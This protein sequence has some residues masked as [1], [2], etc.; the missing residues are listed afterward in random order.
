MAYP[1]CIIKN[2]I[3]VDQTA[4]GYFPLREGLK[5]IKF[6]QN[7]FLS[8]DLLVCPPKVTKNITKGTG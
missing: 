3:K 1:A 6:Y 5:K 7:D 4:K 8:V 2:L